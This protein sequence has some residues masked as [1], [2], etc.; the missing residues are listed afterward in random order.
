MAAIPPPD[1]ENPE[2]S[3]EP[4]RNRVQTLARVLGVDA[5]WL[6]TGTGFR[7]TEQSRRGAGSDVPAEISI[8]AEALRDPGLFK[9]LAELIEAMHDSDLSA[10]QATATLQLAAR[11]LQRRG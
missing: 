11:A 8:T 2:Y 4:R 9:A 1:Y 5:V 10:E 3:T 6:E 7:W